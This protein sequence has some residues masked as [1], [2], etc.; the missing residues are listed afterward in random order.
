MSNYERH[1]LHGRVLTSFK[2]PAAEL[3]AKLAKHDTAKVVDAMGGYGAMHY[4]IKPLTPEMRLAGSA[5]T[6]LTKPGDAL[7]VQK[8]IGLAQPGDVIVVDG[9]GYRDVSVIGERLT[10]FFQR[11]GVAGVVVDGAVRD[12]Q[13]IVEL[14]T[15]VFARATCIRI[16]G[17][18]GPGAINVPIQCGGVPVQPGDVIIGDRDG[19][20]VVPQEAAEGVAEV[21]DAHLEG[22][23]ERLRQVEAGRS[24][25]EVFGLDEKV[26]RWAE[27]MD[28]GSTR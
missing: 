14:R 23:L 27:G 2:R 17:S 28:G 24:V 19:V 4:T 26:A 25:D 22:E 9:S 21:A 16:F 8:A 13:G 1:H 15:P 11:K 3:V 20:A 18:T 5:L 7:Y 12:S 10:Y 6:V